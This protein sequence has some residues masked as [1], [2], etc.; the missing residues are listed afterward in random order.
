MAAHPAP[1]RRFARVALAVVGIA[2]AAGVLGIWL[3]ARASL[4]PEV[5]DMG[6]DAQAMAMT[7]G[8]ATAHGAPTPLAALDRPPTGPPTHSFE[9]VAA[10]SSV[11]V[12][13]YRF[14]G[15]G[16]NRQSPGPELRVRQG[17]GVEVR[18]VN[19]DVAQGVSIHWHGVAVPN[20]QDGVPGVTQDAVWPGQSFTYRFT[21]EHAG[22]FMYHSH[23]VTDAALPA[24]LYG[25]LIVEPLTSAEDVD[26]VVALH[27]RIVPNFA[28]H[29]QPPLPACAKVLEVNGQTGAFRADARPGARVRLRLIDAGQDQHLPVLVGAPFRV[30][31][32][33]GNDVNGPQELR[34]TAL[35]IASGQ[36]YD[37]VFTMPA[38]GAPVALIDHVVRGTAA[39]QFPSAT[40][41]SGTPPAYAFGAPVFDFTTYGTPADD[42][43]LDARGF[44]ASFDMELAS[45]LGFHDGTFT[46]VFTINGRVAPDVPPLAVVPGQRV[47]VRFSELAG[48]D[49]GVHPMHLH[50]HTFTVLTKNGQPLTGSPIRLDTLAVGPGDAYEIAFE[51]DNPGLWMFHCHIANHAARGMATMVDYPDIATPFRVGPASGNAPE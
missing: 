20:P 29:C 23:Q 14:A 6:S 24:G 33:D 50:G 41:G 43:L 9:L 2:L 44:D 51:A 15:L 39:D 27:E 34:D 42:P 28:N 36:R 32:L 4:L 7:S 10:R 31:A 11:D 25:A 35:P 8:V 19:Q 45:H 26:V 5:V 30:V 40:L 38:D 48:G 37:L 18:L 12:G 1:R 21:A 46:R 17:D 3:A 47:R 16:F 22:T 49:D 13:A